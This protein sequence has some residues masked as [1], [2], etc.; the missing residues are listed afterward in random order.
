MRHGQRA[1]LNT[2]LAGSLLLTSADAVSK[3]ASVPLPRP[4]PDVVPAAQP[5]ETHSG[6]ELELAA[7]AS[8]AKQHVVTGPDGWGGS[9]LVR[10]SGVT[11]SSGAPLALDPPAV[12]RCEMALAVAQWLREQVAALLQADTGATPV[13]VEVAG[14]YECRGRNRVKGAKLSEHGT[15]GAIDVSGFQLSDGHSLLLTSAAE[16]KSLREQ[17]RESACRTFTTVLGPGSDGYHETHVHLDRRQRKADY[18]IC[19]WNIDD[20]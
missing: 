4:R 2:C 9:E 11:L 14:S 3:E 5:S 6:C 8:I 7:I 17:V 1:F 20:K 15:G 19:Q 16:S 13:S 10:L 18:R 12:L